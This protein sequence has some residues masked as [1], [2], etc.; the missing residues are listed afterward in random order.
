[1]ADTDATII[2]NGNVL[3]EM[4]DKRVENNETQSMTKRYSALYSHCLTRMVAKG[5]AWINPDDTSD[6]AI[7][8][9][10]ENCYVEHDEGGEMG[11]LVVTFDT[12][13]HTTDSSGNPSEIEGHYEV[14]MVQTKLDLCFHPNF[15]KTLLPHW[16]QF[17]LSKPYIRAAF[18]YQVDPGNDDSPILTLTQFGDWLSL[19]NRGIKEFMCFLPVIN[20]VGTYDAAP[21]VDTIGKL[22]KPPIDAGSFTADDKHW[23]L[24]VDN[25]TYDMKTKIYTRTQQWT[26]AYEWPTLIYS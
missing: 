11:Q 14:D 2:G 25:Y 22:S 7:G 18:Q 16:E 26:Y 4:P 6:D 24:T 3:L 9:I 13:T 17:K 19:W 15:P 20:R 5:A 8:K 23:L 1:M 10:V 21:K 12:T